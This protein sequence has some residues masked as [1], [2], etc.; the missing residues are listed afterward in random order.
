MCVAVG[1]FLNIFFKFHFH[2]NNIEIIINDMSLY[3]NV[4]EI[5]L[6]TVC[7]L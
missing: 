7:C 6:S 1:V 2:Y 4:C 5:I 3:L